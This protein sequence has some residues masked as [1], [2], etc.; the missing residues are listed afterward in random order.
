MSADSISAALE[1]SVFGDSRVGAGEARSPAPPSTGPTFLVE[2]IALAI[3]LVLVGAIIGYALLKTHRA[4]DGTERDRLHAQARVIA[5]NVGQQ[6]DG[7]NR[8]L[9]SV[10]DDYI[11][12]PPHQ[13]ST[14]LSA[15]LKVLSDAIPGV[16]SMVVLDAQGTV[17]ASSVDALLGRDFADRDYFRAPR[18]AQGRATLHVASPYK[19]ALD[20]Y[21]I[22]F[23]RAIIAP[24]GAFEGAAIAAL[25][26][27]YFEVLMRSVLY[28][29]DMWV[30]LGHSDGKVFVTMPRSST[31]LET[32]WQPPAS[33][34]TSAQHPSPSAAVIRGAA[35]GSSEA[36]VTALRSLSPPELH[37]DK[38]LIVAVSRA[39]AD[40]FRAW[41]QQ[42][43]E[44]SIFFVILSAAAA[45][46]LHR[47][48][49]RRH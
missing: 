42:A 45:F 18:T 28:A 6:L 25:E 13:T 4:T 10:R 17:V 26:P 30:S 33:E 36:R 49:G 2:R 1:P 35:G 27:E 8:A 31:R 12:M 47:G 39:E 32:D 43:L 22:V 48:Q 20:N 16:R 11:A 40:I 34:V 9:A 44:Y 37:M 14:L 29:P 7:M 46:G 23:G 5:E 3:A 15:R 21:T 38:T 24:N 19:T 41:R